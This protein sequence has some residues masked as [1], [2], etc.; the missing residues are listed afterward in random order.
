MPVPW[1]LCHVAMHLAAGLLAGEHDKS[2]E[3]VPST[4]MWLGLMLPF[5]SGRFLVSQMTRSHYCP[6]RPPQLVLWIHQ[7][8]SLTKDR[9]QDDTGTLGRI[10]KRLSVWDRAALWHRASSPFCLDGG[11]SET[12]CQPN[13][14]GSAVHGN[15]QS[16]GDVGRYFCWF[17]HL[18]KSNFLFSKGTFLPLFWKVSEFWFTF[19]FC[20]SN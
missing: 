2:F 6:S 14:M 1:D 12:V 18:I 10:W 3:Q 5:L 20:F 9:Y 7:W 11:L 17:W 13:G 16:F 15:S 19:S 8:V 4:H